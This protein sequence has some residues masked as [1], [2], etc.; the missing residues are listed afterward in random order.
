MSPDLTYFLHA[1]PHSGV[2]HLYRQPCDQGT[3][4]AMKEVGATEGWPTFL[5]LKMESPVEPTIEKT[6]G[7]LPHTLKNPCLDIEH[8]K[9]IPVWAVTTAVSSLGTSCRCVRQKTL[10]YRGVVSKKLGS[11]VSRL[12]P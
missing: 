8:L 6:Q 4:N 5:P 12:L 1:L 3:L 10:C 2:H 9:I 7:Q 11:S